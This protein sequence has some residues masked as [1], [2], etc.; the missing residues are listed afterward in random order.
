MWW[1]G[2][3]VALGIKL[4]LFSCMQPAARGPAHW[5]GGAAFGCLPSSI[6][7]IAALRHPPAS[8][9]PCAYCSLASVASEDQE[10]AYEAPEEE[11]ALT[12][13]HGHHKAKVRV[14]QAAWTGWCDGGQPF[15]PGQ[16]LRRS[17]SRD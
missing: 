16:T 7:V 4:A 1:L 3:G 5:P 9:S 13:F 8:P 2:E 6:P 14:M 11:G 15:C 12:R 10:E 17:T